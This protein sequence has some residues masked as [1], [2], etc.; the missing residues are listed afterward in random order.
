MGIIKIAFC[1]KDD[2]GI[3]P[4]AKRRPQPSFCPGISSVKGIII[5]IEIGTGDDIKGIC[6][7]YANRHF[8]WLKISGKAD[9]GISRK[10]NAVFLIFAFPLCDIFFIL[11]QNMRDGLI[12]LEP[13]LGYLP[14]IRNVQ[15][16]RGGL[17]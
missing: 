12:N 3:T 14:G 8:F 10:V 13:F 9:K 7:A 17:S 6:R 16:L 11:T 5:K 2:A 1:I 15:S 4:N